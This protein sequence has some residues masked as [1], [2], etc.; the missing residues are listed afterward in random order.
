MPNSVIRQLAM[1]NRLRLGGMPSSV[2]R[3]MDMIN[4]LT[5]SKGTN[6]RPTC[7]TR[8]T[9]INEGDLSGSSGGGSSGK[10]C[11]K[12][13]SSGGSSGEDGEDGES[14]P[15]NVNI[16]NSYI[17]NLTFYYPPSTKKS[18]TET[19]TTVATI[20]GI[21]ASIITLLKLL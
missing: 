5:Q 18:F 17:E 11:G 9:T 21:L 14:D 8:K 2:A 15:P 19:L 3:Q 12:S 16:Y 4:R 13:G 20:L 7:K 1:I 10:P 6:R